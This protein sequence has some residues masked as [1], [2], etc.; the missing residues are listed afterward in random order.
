MDAS[1]TYLSTELRWALAQEIIYKA[2]VGAL[3]HLPLGG[4]PSIQ[5]YYGQAGMEKTWGALGRGHVELA[6][7]LGSRTAW[8]LG[9]GWIKELTKGKG[10]LCLE[11]SLR[12]VQGADYQ[13]TATSLG[14]EYRF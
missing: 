2:N 12:H 5:S 4:G 11:A 6:T 13:M 7:E 10:G 14:L 1:G 3:T 9:L 8:A